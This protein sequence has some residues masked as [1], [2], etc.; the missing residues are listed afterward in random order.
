MLMRVEA[1]TLAQGQNAE[2]HRKHQDEAAAAARQDKEDQAARNQLLISSCNAVAS[3][4]AD[5]KEG[6][7]GNK[8]Q[9]N[10]VFTV[11]VPLCRR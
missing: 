4:C 11:C 3:S 10:P 7:V 9:V 8:R 2:A 5:L 6:V 1:I